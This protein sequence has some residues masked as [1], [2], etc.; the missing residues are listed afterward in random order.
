MYENVDDDSAD[1]DDDDD[2]GGGGGDDDVRACAIEMHMDTSQKPFCFEIY[3]E[4]A[5]RKSRDTRFVRA[6]AAEMDMDMDMSQDT[7]Y[8]EVYRNNAKHPGY[9]LD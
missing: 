2:D 7:F 9:H 5:G 4:N 6:C 8:A 1:D 3:W